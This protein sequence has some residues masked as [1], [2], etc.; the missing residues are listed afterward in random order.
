M[1]IGKLNIF[2]T[3]P[4]IASVPMMADKAINSDPYIA[5]SPDLQALVIAFAGSLIASF[6]VF[7]IASKGYRFKRIL[8]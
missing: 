6:I 4:E 2:T 1:N 3:F 8:S 5:L 7:A